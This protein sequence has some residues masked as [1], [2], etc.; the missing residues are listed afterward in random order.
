MIRCLGKRPA[1]YDPRVPRLASVMRAVP[2]PAMCNWWA[3]VGSW[4]WCLNDTLGTCVEAGALHCIQQRLAYVGKSYTPSDA[5][6]EALYTRWA[7][8]VPGDPSTDMGTVMA[9]ALADWARSPVMGTSLGAYA[10]VDHVSA[11][12]VKRAIWRCG[13]VLLGLNLPE[14]WRDVDY[15]FDLPSGVGDIAGGHC[16]YLTGFEETALGTEF[17]AVTWG[18]RFRMTERAL[19]LVADEAYAIL[20][21]DWCDAAGVDPAGV[22]WADAEAAMAALR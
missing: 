20:S 16:I 12:W 15:L 7:G 3:D 2:V 6:T 21:R 8:Y 14:A 5:D 22:D 13:G 17:D 9:N 19:P 1:F 18:G 11:D 10:S 4:S